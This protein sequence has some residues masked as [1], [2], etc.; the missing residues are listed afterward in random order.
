MFSLPQKWVEIHLVQKMCVYVF[1]TTI[2]IKHVAE[3]EYSEL[4]NEF[5]KCMKL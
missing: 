2:K 3:N 4:N 1:F 5:N